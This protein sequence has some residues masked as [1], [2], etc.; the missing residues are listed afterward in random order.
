MS[1]LQLKLSAT[2]LILK[3]VDNEYNI[4]K[5]SITRQYPFVQQFLKEDL[6]QLKTFLEVTE[7]VEIIEEL[8]TMRVVLHRPV[9]LEFILHK[10]HNEGLENDIRKE[11]IAK[12]NQLSR[13]ENH[14]L[15]TN[16]RISKIEKQLSYGVILPGYKSVI[17]LHTED[18]YLN[19]FPVLK[20]DKAPER[21][22]E[23]IKD[24]KSR[25]V[26]N[27]CYAYNTE[28]GFSHHN[29]NIGRRINP[30]YFDGHTIEP[31]SYL[32]SLK[33]LYLRH[34]ED[35]V[36][37][38][39]PIYDCVSLEVIRIQGFPDLKRIDFSRLTKLKEVVLYDLPNIEEIRT[40]EHIDIDELCI[41]NCPKLQNMPNLS[42]KVK[43]EK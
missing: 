21:A 33:R 42:S 24:F 27:E 4:Y 23:V 7:N 14:I 20:H 2:N 37:D 40:L 16:A 36:S 5:T 17:P 30:Y 43:I 38:I 12:F 6:S 28:S 22:P 41:V 9:C 34:F 26:H 3:I 25:V 29:I 18:L 13:L 31:I 39:T 32:K 15:E 35:K 19:Y 11:L 10:Q 8:N 1:S